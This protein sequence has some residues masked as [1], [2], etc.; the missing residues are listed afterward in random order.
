MIRRLK[1]IRA[2]NV[3]TPQLPVRQLRRVQW[4]FKTTAQKK[5]LICKQLVYLMNGVYCF[6]FLMLKQMFQAGNS[7]L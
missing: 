2:V 4:R 7:Q 3:Q 6:L 5:E 1:L